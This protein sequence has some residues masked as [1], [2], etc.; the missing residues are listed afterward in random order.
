MKKET[1]INSEGAELELL[2]DG[3]LTITQYLTMPISYQLD[4]YDI[5]SLIADLEKLKDTMRPANTE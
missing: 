1:Y 4:Y 2:P 5:N 3:E